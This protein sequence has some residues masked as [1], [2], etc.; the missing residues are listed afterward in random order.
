M[1]APVGSTPPELRE[2]VEDVLHRKPDDGVAA[3]VDLRHEGA[4]RSLNAVRPRLVVRLAARDE[5]LDL[6]GRDPTH[7]HPRGDLAREHRPRPHVNDGEPGRHAVRPAR[8]GAR[9]CGA[10]RR[11]RAACRARIHRPTRPCP[12]RSRSRRR[13][14]SRR[15]GPSGGRA[16]RRRRPDRRPEGR[17]R[18]RAAPRR[19]T[20]VLE[21]ASRSRRR[22]D[23]DPR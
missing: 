4:G 23:V 12:P 18:R 9:A 14:A 13:P 5:S 3:A 17:I 21:R 6:G 22:G 19:R 15:C 1:T 10:R 20:A 11:D 7:R 8:R 16:R 2:R